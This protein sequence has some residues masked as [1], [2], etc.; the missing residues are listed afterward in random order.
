MSEEHG[1]Q[2]VRGAPLD[3]GGHPSPR[4][5]WDWDL[6]STGSRAGALPRRRSEGSADKGT[7]CC[8]IWGN[9]GNLKC[10]LF[11]Q[12]MAGDCFTGYLAFLSFPPQP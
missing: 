3:L 10:F 12:V 8:K 1:A 11:M 4:G 2:P 5:R 6:E 9:K 7:S